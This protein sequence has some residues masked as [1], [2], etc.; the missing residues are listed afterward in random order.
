MYKTVDLFAGIGGIRRG[1]E[2]TNRFENVLSAEIDK[3]A[4]ETYKHLFGEDPYN[5]VTS[6]EF[7]EKISSIDYDVLLAGFPCQAF[8]IAGKKE[9]FMDKTRGTLFFDIADILKR[10]RPKAFLLENVEGLVR[11]KKGETFEIILQT[12]VTE[13]NYKVIGV[14][15]GLFPGDLIYNPNDFVLNSR[16]FGVPQN[17]PRVYIIGFDRKRYG[18]L[19]DELPFKKLPQRREGEPIY[20]DLNDLLEFG[21]DPEYYLSSGYLESLKEHKNRHKDKGNG[22]GYIVVNAK[23]IE[24]P[25]SNAILATGGSGKERNL[26]Y[27]PQ[28]HIGGTIVKGKKTPLNNEGIRV[29]TPREWGKL[30]GFIGYAFMKDGKDEFSF[31]PKMSKA[32]QYKQFGNSVTIPVIEVL[33]NEIAK[34]LD[35]LEDNASKTIGVIEEESQEKVKSAVMI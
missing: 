27:D 8:S 1:F 22:Y 30:Q 21:A 3:Y 32:Q 19:V 26:V 11:H 7:K 24:N 16:Y 18:N 35:F 25:V 17:R 12:L 9:G 6:E 13:L 29:M 4:C 15:E 10:T 33:A 14:N 20:K 28:D 5:D 31:P 34:A 2:L 23:G